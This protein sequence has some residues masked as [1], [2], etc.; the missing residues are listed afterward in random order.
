MLL[1]DRIFELDAK[2]VEHATIAEIV[3]CHPAYVRAALWRETTKQRPM[4]E[5]EWLQAWQMFREGKPL[6][7]IEKHYGVGHTTIACGFSRRGWYDRSTQQVLPSAPNYKSPPSPSR[8]T[9]IDASVAEW[10]G[11]QEFVAAF[12]AAR[13]NPPDRIAEIISRPVHEVQKFL[14]AV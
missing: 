11:E 1:K 12:L 2:G 3:G 6:R 13:N 14:E 4:L 7:E 9:F 5:T 10:S 8:T